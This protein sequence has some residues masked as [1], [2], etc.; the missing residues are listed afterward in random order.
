MYELPAARFEQAGVPITADALGLLL[1]EAKLH[2]YCTMLL[3]REAARSGQAI[4]AVT[5][6]IVQAALLTASEDEAW[7]LRDDVD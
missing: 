7:T 2:P 6:I 3:A 5:N 4:G 1:D